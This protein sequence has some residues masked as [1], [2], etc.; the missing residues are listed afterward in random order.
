MNYT[1]PQYMEMLRGLDAFNPDFFEIRK[2]GALG[3]GWTFDR[4]TGSPISEGTVKLGYNFGTRGNGVDP[5]LLAKGF[6]YRGSRM[7]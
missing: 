6:K 1:L 4:E 7:K 3:W 5:T 2:S